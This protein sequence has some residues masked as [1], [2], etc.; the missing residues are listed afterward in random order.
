MSHATTY[1]VCAAIAVLISGLAKGGFAGLGSI[2]MPVMAIGVDP[3]QGA[4]ILLPILIVQDVISV[5]SFRRTYSGEIIR[6]MLPGMALGVLV[7]YVYASRLSEK[8]VLGKSSITSS[9]PLIGP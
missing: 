8:A 1:Y 2:A 3:I 9:E 6:V 4:A 5:W 7:G